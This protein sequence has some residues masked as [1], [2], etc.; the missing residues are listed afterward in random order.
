MNVSYKW[1]K[2][3]VDFDLTPQETADAQRRVSINL[4]HEYCP[5]RQSHGSTLTHTHGIEVDITLL[6]TYPAATYELWSKADKPTVAIIVGSTGLGANL[7]FQVITVAQS[8]CRTIIHDPHQHGK[9]LHG[10][11]STDYLVHTWL[12]GSNRI[13]LIILDAAHKHWS[14]TDAVIGKYGLGTHHL[15]DT[16]LTWSQTKTHGCMDVRTVD[17]EIV[18]HLDK[19]LRIEFTHQ[20][21]THPVATLC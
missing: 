9:H 15:A 3:Y 12:E 16:Y 13:A 18:Q 8:S 20:I 4:L 19:L 21:S 7:S 10:I 6:T 17:A 11:I 1:L 14:S 2:E 5:D